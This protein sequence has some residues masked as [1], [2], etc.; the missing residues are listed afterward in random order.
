MPRF[1]TL[2]LPLLAI[3]FFIYQ[4]SDPKLDPALSQRVEMSS[5]SSALSHPA[6]PLSSASSQTVEGALR[7]LAYSRLSAPFPKQAHEAEDLP[8][9]PIPEQLVGSPELL[10]Y[11]WGEID[12][13]L[14]SALSPAEAQNLRSMIARLISPAANDQPWL[15]WGP[16]TP[17]QK[18][19]AFHQAEELTGM[20]SSGVSLFANQFLGAGRWNNTATDGS[21]NFQQ[22]LPMTLTWSIIPDG[23]IIPGRDAAPPAPSNFRAWMASIYG[24]SETGPAADQGWFSIFESA[25]DAMANTCGVNFVYE[26]ADDQATVVFAAG[27]QLGLRG[28]IRIGARFIDGDSNVLAYATS[29]GGGDI[30]F[31]SGDSA[32]DRTDFNSLTLFN[33]TTH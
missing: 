7:Q 2:T 10:E 23:T 8:K 20:R 33:T 12:P 9:P 29:P 21:G 17:K 22:G 24:G 11:V 26:P 14:R 30:I 3:W 4:N 27:G 25:F 18:V 5:P 6:S 31:D 15:C 1:L 19:L 16:G 28:D 32:F 13:D